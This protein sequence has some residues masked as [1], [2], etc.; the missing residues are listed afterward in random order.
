MDTIPS[1][2]NVIEAINMVCAAFE[3]M[4]DHVHD[5]R[6]CAREAGRGQTTRHQW[7]DWG[8]HGQAPTILDLTARQDQ[9]MLCPRTGQS[10]GHRCNFTGSSGKK[11]VRDV[12]HTS[13]A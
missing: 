6:P 8:Q 3:T 5:V 9:C 1:P 4:S 10:A 12:N 13:S 2:A 11:R 7:S